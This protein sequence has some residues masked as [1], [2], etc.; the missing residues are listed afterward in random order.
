MAS[1]QLF[2]HYKSVTALR[3]FAPKDFASAQTVQLKF[4]QQFGSDVGFEMSAIASVSSSN[5]HLLTVRKN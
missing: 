5:E 4:F 3:F 2:G 1:D